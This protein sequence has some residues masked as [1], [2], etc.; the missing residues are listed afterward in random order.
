MK[1]NVD[2]LL[3]SEDEFNEVVIPPII[4]SEE[5]L[6]SEMDKQFTLDIQK[7]FPL[8]SAEKIVNVVVVTFQN[9]QK[10]VNLDASAVGN[11]VV[12]E[13][14]TG[15]QQSTSNSGKMQIFANK[16]QVLRNMV[17]EQNDSGPSTSVAGNGKDKSIGRITKNKNTKLI[18][19]VTTRKQEAS[20]HPKVKVKGNSITDLKLPGM[21]RTIIHNSAHGKKANIWLFWHVS[22]AAPTV[23][24]ITKQ[25]ITVAIGNVMVTGVHAYCLTINRRELWEELAELSSKNCPWLVIGDFNVVL[26]NAEKKGG[27]RPLRVSIQDF[28]EC[29]DV[30][31][32][33]QASRS[34]IFFS[35][36]NNK[37]GK[38]RIICDLD[39][40]FVNV[41]WLEL[42]DGWSYKV[43][44]RGVSDHEALLGS[45]VGIL[46]PQNVP[47][48]FKQS[49]KIWNWEIFGDLKKK[50]QSAEK[51]VLN[52][53]LLSDADPE[54]ITLL[55]ELVT[56]RGRQEMAEQQYNE[57]MQAKSRVKWVKGG[58]SNTAFFHVNMKIRQAQNTIVE[59]EDKNGTV[60]TDQRILANMLVEHF[61][62]KFK[63]Q[64]VDLTGSI[65]NVIP[66]ILTEEDNTILDDVPTNIE[67]KNVVFGMDANSSPG[68]D[69]FPGSFF[70]FAWEIVGE[71]MIKVIQYCWRCRF[72]PKGLNSNF[73]FLLPKVKGAKRVD[74]FRP[75]GLANFSFKVITRIITTRL[76][77]VVNQ[78]VSSQQGAFIK[79]KTIHEKIVMASELIN[80][81]N[82]KKRDELGINWLK[83]LFTSARISVLINGGPCGFFEVSRGL[84]QGDPLS[85]TLFV[86]AEEVLSRNLIQMVKEGKIQAMVQ[87]HGVKPSHL[88]FA[89]DIFVF[90]N[91]HKKSLDKLMELLMSYQSASGQVINKQKSK[92][93]VGGTT[94][95][96]RKKITDQMQMELSEFPDKYLD[97]ILGPGRV[98]VHQ[99]WGVVEMIYPVYTMFVYKWPKVI[100]HECERIIRNFLWTGDPSEKKLVT[101][102][103]EEINAQIA[104]GGLGLRRLEVINKALLMTLLW[105]IL[106]EDEEWTRFMKD[107]FM[108]KNGEWIQSYKQSSI[109]PG[110]ILVIHDVNEGSRWLVRNGKHISVWMDKWVYEYTLAEKYPDNTFIQQ[111]KD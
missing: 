74:Q 97:V 54:N 111:H 34:G 69:G 18:P 99:V 2:N 87:R 110:L 92:F 75:I 3:F 44:N 28:R 38:K 9:I 98:K 8:L 20:T 100:I 89:D 67:T 82:I 39:K 106:T 33:M 37:A 10:Q 65:F 48:R 78:L 45:V 102:K 77:R 46:K 23:I 64:A 58:G 14:I 4:S 59:M 86:L 61:Q 85:P 80:K 15:G 42:H 12:K 27:R 31:K 60:V 62:N 105:R 79:G 90:C 94:D 103:W 76:S 52:A 108:N 56:A 81:M 93:F 24:S 71:D 72:I 1:Q 70:K 6:D 35:W 26:I 13:I 41:K 95:S 21:C 104:E 96:K 84:R 36:C 16:F 73:L 63:T 107:K 19:N 55:N 109:W 53:S 40:Y 22:L 43:G 68:P 49:V 17:E 51:D 5:K 83:V 66:K 30:C 29:L 101:V 50:V 91:G 47:F 11:E 57:L 88:L 7:D 25:A 32:L